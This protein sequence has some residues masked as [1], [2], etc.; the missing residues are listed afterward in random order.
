MRYSYRHTFET[1]TEALEAVRA[2]R[3]S[4]KDAHD[5]M[6]QCL[7]GSNRTV[8][9]VGTLARKLAEAEIGIQEELIKVTAP[10]TI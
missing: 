6:L 10:C 3:K 9:R 4:V 1:L 2:A 7:G 5:T 8:M